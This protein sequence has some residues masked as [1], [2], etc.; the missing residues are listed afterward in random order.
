MRVS[1]KRLLEPAVRRS[2]GGISELL[3]RRVDAGMLVRPDAS[4]DGGYVLTK[5]PD[6]IRVTDVLDALRRSPHFQPERRQAAGLDRVA[7]QIWLELDRALERSPA[8]W[9]LQQIIGQEDRGTAPAV[10]AGPGERDEARHSRGASGGVER[11]SA[12]SREVRGAWCVD[13]RAARVFHDRG[14]FAPGITAHDRG[15]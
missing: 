14:G 9:S 11:D 15:R 4:G 6:R 12:A 2:G 1:S 13:E 3:D 5:P 7:S 10:P 8:N